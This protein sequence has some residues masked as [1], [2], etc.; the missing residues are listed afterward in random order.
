MSSPVET[1]H[2]LSCPAGT[3]PSADTS[4]KQGPSGLGSS[5]SQLSGNRDIHAAESLQS[6]TQNGHGGKVPS[7]DPAPL[8]SAMQTVVA[9]LDD[10]EKEFLNCKKHV[11]GLER[12]L[13]V[14]SPGIPLNTLL[15]TKHL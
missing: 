6:A 7:V 12:L 4:S 8:P 9:F 11:H 3:S 15:H 2:M 1:L 10:L 14:V 5:S 13:K